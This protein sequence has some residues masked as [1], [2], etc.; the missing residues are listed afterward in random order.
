MRNS[1]VSDVTLVLHAGTDAGFAI[2]REL[3][4]A[5][6]RIVVTSR[7]AAELTRILT[8]AAPI[9]CWPSQ[10]TPPTMCSCVA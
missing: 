3:L 4:G 5:G 6:R 8:A 10:P 7:H 2:A 1:S 9:R